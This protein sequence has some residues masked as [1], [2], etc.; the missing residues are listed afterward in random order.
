MRNNKADPA[1]VLV[2]GASKGIGRHLAEHFAASG[3]I[4]EGCSRGE[5]DL[6]AEGYRH[7]RVDV[8]DE[9]Q[10]KA[11]I[12][13][14]RKS[15][16]RLDILINNAG[17]A[18]MN[19]S[20][21][22]PRSTVERLLAVNV[23]GAFVVCREAAKLMRKSGYGRIVNMTTVAVPMRIE[24]ESVY[25]ASK[26]ALE[27]LT[28]ILAHELGGLGIT[29]NAVGPAPIKTD[30][31]AGVPKDKIAKIIDRLAIKRMGTHDDVLNVVDFFVR[32][33]SGYVTGQVLYLGGAG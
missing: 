28:R 14:I 33:E 3:A 9:K 18:A 23:I 7:H 11:M 27:T 26:S 25:A 17:A 2:T 24:G 16:G 8:V 29:C 21:L 12:S 31:I 1:V 30:L 20:L 6:N 5:S 13:A 4:V 32:P 19:H 10:V 22:T 15:H